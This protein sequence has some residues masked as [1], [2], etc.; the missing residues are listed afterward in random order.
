MQA[1]QFFWISLGKW[2]YLLTG[3]PLAVLFGLIVR[4]IGLL[5]AP[6]GERRQFAAEC[7]SAEPRG[8]FCCMTVR[9]QDTKRLK[10]TAA[11]LSAD[12]ALAG[13]SP[14]DTVRIAV[15]TDAF[16]AGS[17]PAS[18]DAL[19]HSTPDGII[20]TAKEY[21]KKRRIVLLGILLR[22]ILLCGAALAVFLTAMHFCFES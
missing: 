18:P 20:L 3:I 6:F 1:S 21:R 14:G 19:E 7:L 8:D 4:A 22:Q 15:K 12:P 5:T 11:F 9:F 2:R 13:I 10:H 17:Y 16:C